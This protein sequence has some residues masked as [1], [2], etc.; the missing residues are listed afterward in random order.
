MPQAVGEGFADGALRAALGQSHFHGGLDPRDDGGAAP[1]AFALPQ[2]G[3]GFA[4]PQAFFDPV[5]MGDEQDDPCGVLVGGD[6]E[7]FGEV[8]PDVGEAG[9]EPGSGIG[10]GV[11]LVGSV[12]VTLDVSAKVSAEGFDELIRSATDAPV[13]EEAAAGHFGDPQVAL[14]RF[15]TAGH[16]VAHGGFIKL[17]VVRGE[18]LGADGAGDGLEQADGLVDPVD[19]EVAWEANAVAVEDGLLAVKREVVDVFP[20]EQVGEQSGCWQ[21]ADERGGRGGRD[22]G[23][24]V[25]AFLAA[26]LRADDAAFEKPRRGDVEQLGDFLADA[27]ECS[28]IGGYEVGDDLGGLGGLGGEVFQAGDPGAVGGALFRAG[29]SWLFTLVLTSAAVLNPVVLAQVWTSM[30]DGVLALCILIFAVSMVTWVKQEDGRF[31]VAGVAAMMLALNLK[32]SAI[33]IFV[34]LC[35][36]ACAGAYLMRGLP[37][38]Y[39]AAALLFVPA[40]AAIFLFGWSPYMQNFLEQGHIFHPIMGKEAIDIMIGDGAAYNNTPEVLKEMSAPERFFFSLFSETHAGYETL[41]RLKLPFTVSPE[42]LRAAGGVDVRLAGFGPFFSGSL[43]LTLGAAIL[44]YVRRAEC[45]PAARVLLFVAGALL[46]SVILMPQN[47]W[48]RYVPQFWFVPVCVAAAA[49]TVD[50]RLVQY[51]GAALVAAALA[52]SLA[53]GGASAWLSA[54]RSMDADAQIQRLAGTGQ[55]YCVNPDMVESRIFLMQGAGIDAVYTPVEAMACAAPESFDG[56]GPDRT[57]GLIC[58]CPE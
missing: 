55:R 27:L 22:D 33:P 10:L 57:G 43:L 2:G 40:V 20:D 8:A 31:L 37:K 11:R 47:W 44:L 54:N 17:E 26:E 52:G 23:R 32:F 42:E 25:A 1:C 24:E 9:D 30:N 46:V 12:A 38:A 7:G 13:V 45:G 53:A 35:G 29:Y 48:A 49:L 28:G 39:T 51:L 34:I 5:E 18:C 3:A 58:A 4:F 36:F 56:Y 16:E 19:D 6:V 21:P 41:P 15:A 14:L 50:R